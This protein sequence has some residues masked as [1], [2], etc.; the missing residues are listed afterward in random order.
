MFTNRVG[1]A[2]E[3]YLLNIIEKQAKMIERLEARVEE[4]ERQLGLNSQNSSKPPS[5]D[6][7]KKASKPKRTTSLRQSSGRASGGQKGHKGNTLRSVETPDHVIDHTVHVCPE[8]GLDLRNERSEECTKRQVFDLPEIG[9][10]VT[11]HRAYGA[12]CPNCKKTFKAGFPNDVTAPVQY[13]PVVRNTAVYL[14][15]YQLIPEDR[16]EELM[17]DCFNVS[18]SSA[19]IMQ[20][21]HKSGQLLQPFMGTVKE[22]LEAA[23]IVHLD[24][25]GIRI[26]GHKS[27]WLHIAGNEKLS[28]YRVAK[29]GDV[30]AI[31]GIQGKVVHDNY[32]PYYKHLPTHIHCLCNTHHERELIA[33][34]D[35]DKEPW[36]NTMLRLLRPGLRKKNQNQGV[37]PE[38]WNARF[39]TI[40]DE[41]LSKAI[42]W[43]EWHAPPKFDSRAK[44]KGHNLALR[45]KNRKT[46]VLRYLTEADVPYTN[47]QAERDIRMMKTR[48]KISGGFRSM[49]GAEVFATVRSF[50]STAKKQA[51]NILDALRNPFKYT[52]SM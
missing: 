23:G 8:C 26:S 32:Q 9:L 1:V 17:K 25:T 43:H 2:R 42:A 37:V 20:W 6:G 29:R 35:I 49:A 41:I 5:S 51:W 16:L 34:R 27:M 44:R 15:Q 22:R 7:L 39:Q 46:D 11:E 45:L 30:E 4:L 48:Q 12:L 47:N 50:V 40:Y 52:A 21:V 13:G 28:W 38:S 24:E 33:V 3:N 19:S 18:A 14:H 36:A 10:E 31:K